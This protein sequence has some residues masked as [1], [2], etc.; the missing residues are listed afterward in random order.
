MR[1]TE[2]FAVPT[3]CEA[4][5]YGSAGIDFDSVNM[6]K[7][8]SMSA[9]IAFGA[10]T[11]NSVL[12]VYCGAT[13]GAKTTAI[14]FKY[15]VTGADFKASGADVFGAATSVTGSSGLTLTAASF[16]HRTIAIDVQS[17]QVTADKPFLTIE[18]DA[19]ATVL[20]VGAVGVC[21]ARQHGATN[22]TVLA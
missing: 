22:P 3:L 5:D 18:I 17:D 2:K 10:L 4:K 16:D 8:H 7:V 11:G 15:C 6:G 12:K 14:D 9:L 19:T 21:V 1:I 20:N 13:A